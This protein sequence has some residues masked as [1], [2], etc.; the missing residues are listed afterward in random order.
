MSARGG[1]RATSSAGSRSGA[2][3]LAVLLA[4]VPLA[5]VRVASAPGSTSRPVHPAARPRERPDARR[6]RRRR[7]WSSRSR[8]A[9]TR[10]RSGASTPWTSSGAA[11]GA[12][13]VV[14]LLWTSRRPS[15]SSA[16]PPRRPGGRC[17]SRPVGPGA[18]LRARGRRARRSVSWPSR[19]PT[20]TVA[21]RLA[22]TTDAAGDAVPLSR[23]WTP[24]SRVVGYPPPPGGGVRAGLLRPR[25]RAGAG[26]AAGRPDA[27][28]EGAAPRPAV[29]SATCCGGRDRRA[30]DR[31]RRRPRHPQRADLGRAPGGRD[32]AQPRRSATS[33]TT[34]CALA[35]ARRTRCRGVHT[36]SAT[37][38]RRSRATHERYDQIHI[39]FTDTL[40]A[41][42]GA[43]LRA[44]REQ[45]LHR[46]GVRRVPRPPA[47]PTGS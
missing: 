10:R 16:W 20:A 7:A 32:R 26:H 39:G 31:R 21:Y 9:A 4:V 22:P 46:R 42:L 3:A 24:L 2:R 29:A 23:P 40:S 36:R 1:S 38:A 30:G 37:A 34:S 14:P 45:P 27:R 28:L 18:A 33:S 35:R 12:V 43:G 25:L 15:C 13:V 47:R 11:P 41:E 19:P 44:D 8:S 5:L 6:L 17:S